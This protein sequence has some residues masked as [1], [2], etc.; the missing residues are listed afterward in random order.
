VRC[1]AAEVHLCSPV[2]GCRCTRLL[3]HVQQVEAGNAFSIDGAPWTDGRKSSM[4]SSWRYSFSILVDARVSMPHRCADLLSREPTLSLIKKQASWL[5]FCFDLHVLS[6]CMWSVLGCRRACAV[7]QWSQAAEQ[8]LVQMHECS[9]G[10]MCLL[11]CHAFSLL[12][13]HQHQAR[14]TCPQ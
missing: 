7:S 9:Q 10:C 8:Q 4:P 1:A 3:R 11:L 2:V 14:T 12:T 5:C 13:S 6:D